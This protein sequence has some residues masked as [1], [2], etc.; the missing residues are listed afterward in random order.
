MISNKTHNIDLTKDIY[1]GT[2]Q[3]KLN[4]AREGTK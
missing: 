3:R 2:I 1:D 4:N